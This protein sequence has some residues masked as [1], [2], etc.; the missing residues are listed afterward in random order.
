MTAVT[1]PLPLARHELVALSSLFA[2]GCVM[3]IFVAAGPWIIRTHGYQV[4]IPAVIASGF[5]TIAAT[6]FS[7]AAPA[8]I[9]IVRRARLRAGD[10]AAAGR[11]RAVPFDRP[12]S[13]HLGR[14][15][16]GGR[17]QPL[18]VC[19]GRSGARSSA[20]CHDL[21]AHQPCRLCGDSL[22][23]ARRDVLLSGH[24]HFRDRH[25]DA[26]RDG[27]VRDRH[28]RGSDRPAAPSRSTS[29]HCRRLRMASAGDLGNR[30]QWPCRGADG[31][32][33]D[34]RCV[35]S[36][37][38]ETCHRR[39]RGGIGHHRETLCAVHSAG[40]LAALRLA[41]T[42]RR[43]R[44]DLSLLSALSR[45]RQRRVRLSRRLPGGRRPYQRRRHLAHR[46]RFRR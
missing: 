37:A 29:R 33:D 22:P 24:A 36:G 17:H 25:G 3:L 46:A 2:A 32:A 16:A 18:Q 19:T 45:R 11:R 23:A 13:L 31:R 44:G 30:Q 35:A 34:A 43:H 27:D 26:A 42:A 9:G 20:R 8:R 1:K 6:R 12:L 14:P 41:R 38:R 7:T 28:C 39:G 10:A 4:F 21:S 5:L 15:R 40:V